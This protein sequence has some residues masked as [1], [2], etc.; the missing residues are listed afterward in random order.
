MNTYTISLKTKKMKKR[1]PST[2]IM[3]AIGTSQNKRNPELY[4]V[5]SLKNNSSVQSLMMFKTLLIAKNGT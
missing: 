2:K 4:K 5:L 3:E 1:L